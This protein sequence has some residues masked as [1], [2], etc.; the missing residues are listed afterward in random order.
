MEFDNIVNQIYMIALNES[1]LRMHE[2]LLPEHYLYA[3]LLFQDGRKILE[4]SGADVTRIILELSY[5]LDNYIEP[6]EDC[7][8][9][10]QSFGFISLVNA[11]LFNAKK[12]N[13]PNIGINELLISFF[14]IKNSYAT[15]VLAKNGVTR[16]SV[17]RYISHG[18]PTKSKASQTD[19]ISDKDK[20]F[21]EKYTI[22]LTKKAFKGDLDP[23]I[24]REDVLERTIQVLSR[25]IKNN[26]VHVGEPGVGKTALVE[27]IAQMISSKEAP[28][29]LL[30][31]K[32]YYLDI[33]SVIAGTK[34]RGDFEERFI[35]I[36]DII[37]QEVHPI[38]YI[39]E[40]HSIIG[41][42]SISGSSMDATSILKPYLLKSNLRIIGSTT[43]SEYKK[44]FEKDR[45][46]AR[47][48]QK[49]DISE[50]TLDDCIKILHGIKCKYEDF[51]NVTYTDSAI[52]SACA[53][54]SKYMTDKHLP[55]KAIDVI[56]E[57]GAYARIKADNDKSPILIDK[58]TIE[59][60]ISKIAGIKIEKV[61][62]DEAEN[63]RNLDVALKSELFG[64]DTAVESVVNAIKASRSGLNDTERPIAS[65]LFVGPTGV[66]KTELTK[67][68]AK[69]LQL[70]LQRFDMSEYQEKHSVA[71]LIGAPPGYVGYEEGGLLTD[72]VSKT[73]YCIVLLDEIE[74]AH[75][76]IYNILLQ[77]MDYGFLTSSTGKKA[78]F[79]NVILI[80]T[81][82]SGARNIGKRIIGFDERTMS[83]D[84]IY[85]ELEKTFAPEFRNRL[86][87]T[88]LF[89][90][91]NN[92]MAKM[93]AEKAVNKL[94]ER[95]ITK[96]VKL[97]LKEDATVYIAEK[98]LTKEFGAREINRTVDL[99]I[100]KVL[101]DEVLFGRLKDGGTV[102]ISFKNNKLHF[103]YR[104][105]TNKNK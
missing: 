24:G 87:E 12:A 83:V 36:L 95:L 82:N 96:N 73:P 102:T 23:L 71:R 97:I 4:N 105:R 65:L 45:A 8:Q 29:F 43:F 40:I 70:P 56:D 27:G 3:C 35:K 31:S 53:L 18:T 55:D 81:S 33:G 75:H 1:K 59:T 92:D 26:P 11:A 42:G 16:N 99:E 15:T 68:L 47:R 20:E 104:K 66:G 22:E 74:K 94:A 37:T 80:M 89:N 39:D 34:Y 13:K 54:S 64:Q 69:N 61:N 85:N 100:K 79:R 7:E 77:V 52:K 25:R 44:I 98:G 84:A 9:P 41:A 91:L 63:L 57:A 50:P 2:Y 72:A 76:D 6:I 67:L 58:D 38:I 32:I 93:I 60:I 30:D 19:T 49:I 46:L 62:V 48:F 10:E 28:S 14:D 78:D 101:T 86:D 51:H 21:L 17:L 90:G 103:A 88:I 5:F